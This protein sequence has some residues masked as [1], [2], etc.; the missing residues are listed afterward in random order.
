MNKVNATLQDPHPYISFNMFLC[1]PLTPPFLHTAYLLPAEVSI[2]FLEVA[3]GLSRTTYRTS[4]CTQPQL[5]QRVTAISDTMTG[6]KHPIV[7]LKAQLGGRQWDVRTM[8]IR[9]TSA[10]SLLKK[11]IE[12]IFPN[13]WPTPLLDVIIELLS[14]IFEPHFS[15]IRISILPLGQTFTVD[16][17]HVNSISENAHF[18]CTVFSKLLTIKSIPSRISIHN[19]LPS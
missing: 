1:V 9:R 5:L 3:I 13:Y 7:S 11:K 17:I 16:I 2:S 6:L 18:L 8:N 12:T 14:S 4:S 10:S 19:H 15:A